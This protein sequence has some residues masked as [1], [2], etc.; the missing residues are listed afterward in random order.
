MTIDTDYFQ[1][2][3]GGLLLYSVLILLKC[4]FKVEQGYLAVITEFGKALTR[5]NPGST[6]LLKTFEPGLHWKLPWQKVHKVS[7]ME[8]SLDFSGD[9]AIS[10]MAE[11]GTLLQLDSKLRYYQTPEQLYT[12]LFHLKNPVEHIKGLYTCLL[13][14]EIASFTLKANEGSQPLLGSV[15]TQDA[16]SY[17]LVRRE[18]RLLNKRI[19]EFCRHSI[20]DHY[21][22]RYGAVDLTDILPPDELA[23]ALN[24][25]I[26]A[27]IE[28]DSLF[29]RSEGECQQRILS[30]KKGVA[31]GKAQA[32]AAE[33][34]VLTLAKF[35]TEMKK[36]GTLN[37]YVERRRVEILSESRAVFRRGL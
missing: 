4:S 27:Q 22:I 16:G 12:Y 18:R 32:R 19:E 8:Q 21:G 10:A 26:N 6:T 23:V 11:D 31:I 17:A 5:V 37:Q 24:A 34:E 36:Q 25:V 29:A 9:N 20:N 28:A 2:F 15:F 14:N 33:I 3:I 1:G 35:L 7:M 30:A 13:R